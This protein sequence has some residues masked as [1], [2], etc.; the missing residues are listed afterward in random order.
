MAI[1]IKLAV[2]LFSHLCISTARPLIYPYPAEQEYF[3]Q[4]WADQGYP[5]TGD[6]NF[7]YANQYVDPSYYQGVDPTAYAY[8]AYPHDDH[9]YT[10]YALV[11]P[12]Y[13]YD[14]H[15]YGY[16]PN[17]PYIEEPMNMFENSFWH[18]MTTVN[19]MAQ[20]PFLVDI[21]AGGEDFTGMGDLY[22]NLID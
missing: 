18:K 8:P 19:N 17:Y 9:A 4:Y 6:L 7:A 14:A 15:A 21:T 10:Y 11:D 13:P 3:Y 1:F 20:N 16:D 2:L 22:D 12:S 5:P